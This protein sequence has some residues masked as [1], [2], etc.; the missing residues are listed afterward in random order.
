[1]KGKRVRPAAALSRTAPVL[2]LTASIVSHASYAHADARDEARA[3]YARGEKAHKAGDHAAAMRAF[4]EADERLPKRAALVAALQEAELVDPSPSDAPLVADLLERAR[5]EASPDVTKVGV[6][7]ALRFGNM[8]G[9]L[10]LLCAA[11]PCRAR[12]GGRELPADR[13][14]TVA[15]GP[16]EVTLLDAQGHPL[17]VVSVPVQAGQNAEVAHP[18]VAEPHAVEPPAAASTQTLPNASTREPSVARTP[19]DPKPETP[20]LEA[21]KDAVVTT[22]A[23]SHTAGSGKP[24]PPAAFWVGAG[25]SALLLAGGLVGVGLISPRLYDDF[26]SAGCKSAPAPS[27]CGDRA[28]DGRAVDIVSNV[29]LIGG[30]V[31]GIASVVAGA[32]FVRW[33]KPSVGRITPSFSVQSRGGEAKLQVR[34]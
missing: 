22:P 17:R 32:A 30:A 16:A 8:L 6:R 21:R 24:L 1:V 12:L 29:L 33:D 31:V 14:T 13:S 25:S 34:F 19:S 5:R 23:D 3:A 2:L 10:R 26:E 4:A 9:S 20:N 11:P 15:A 7:V 18:G 28:S 27:E